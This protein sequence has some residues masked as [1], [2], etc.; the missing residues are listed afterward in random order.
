M[1]KPV[2]VELNLTAFGPKSRV[3]VDGADISHG[4]T[5]ITVAAGVDRATVVNLT[6]FADV[7]GTVETDEVE[8]L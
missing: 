3:V 5:S 4:V 8:G 6:M 2:Q 7:S 1:T